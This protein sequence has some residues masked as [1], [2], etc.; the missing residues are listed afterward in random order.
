[1]NDTENPACPFC[2]LK[3]A[4]Y[5][6]DKVRLRD[7]LP[8]PTLL[9]G[10]G[11]YIHRGHYGQATPSKRDI[12]LR[13]AIRAESGVPIPPPQP[14]FSTKNKPHNNVNAKATRKGAR[15]HLTV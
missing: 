9:S 1:V 4:P 10:K 15:S 14:T 8:N 5:D 2:Q 7:V 6:R 13:A 11:P 3:F 12:V